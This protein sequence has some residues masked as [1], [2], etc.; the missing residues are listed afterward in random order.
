MINIT[1]AVVSRSDPFITFEF[2]PECPFVQDKYEFDAT[3]TVI[4]GKVNIFIL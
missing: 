2:E 3:V 1:H 4:E